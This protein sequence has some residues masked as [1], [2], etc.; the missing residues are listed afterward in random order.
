MKR[1]KRT[2]CCCSL[3]SIS[4]TGS[5]AVSH[6]N[7]NK[8]A[9]LTKKTGKRRRTPYNITPRSDRLDLHCAPIRVLV[10]S[11]TRCLRLFGDSSPPQQD[12]LQPV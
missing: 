2:W 7:A 6:C 5:P 12:Q 1:M 11:P 10:H 3:L 9:L 8:D 4:S